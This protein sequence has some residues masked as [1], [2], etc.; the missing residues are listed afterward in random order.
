M[1]R[2]RT[3]CNTCLADYHA[4]P[5]MAS[6]EGSACSLCACYAYG[7]T[8]PEECVKETTEDYNVDVEQAKY[9]MREYVKVN[10]DLVK[11]PMGYLDGVARLRERSAKQ[12]DIISYDSMGG[13][14]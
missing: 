13:V 6:G 2:Q 7:L 1:S 12:A 5:G 11:H 10:D 9:L 8:T 3:M 4:L 14:G